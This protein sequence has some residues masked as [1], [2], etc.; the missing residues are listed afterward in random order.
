NKDLYHQRQ[1]IVEHV[2]GTIKPGIHIFYYVVMNFLGY[3]LKRWI[4]IIGAKALIGY[5]QALI[6]CCFYCYKNIYNSLY[7]KKFISIN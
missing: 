2:F 6:L 4:N 5:F 7:H 1:M 3:N